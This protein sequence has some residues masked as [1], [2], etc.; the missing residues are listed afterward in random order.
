[1]GY[2]FIKYHV[3]FALRDDIAKKKK[4]LINTS[5]KYDK[6]TLTFPPD[7]SKINTNHYEKN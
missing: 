5:Y 1:M 7:N 4:E 2:G 6:P 3:E